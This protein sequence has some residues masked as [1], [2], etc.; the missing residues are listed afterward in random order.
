MGMIS[1]YLSN[2][3]IIKIA[4]NMHGNI[5]TPRLACDKCSIHLKAF[6][7]LLLCHY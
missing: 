4:Q 1:V 6:I 5:L 2:K 7:L 3:V